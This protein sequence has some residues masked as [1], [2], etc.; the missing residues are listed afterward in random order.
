[1][2]AIKVTITGKNK[3]THKLRNFSVILLF[4]SLDEVT[5]EHSLE[6]VIEYIAI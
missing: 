1:M 4:L 3:E 5:I 6:A 2:Y